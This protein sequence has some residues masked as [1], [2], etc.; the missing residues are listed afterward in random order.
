MQ[1]RVADDTL[2][3][4]VDTAQ[5]IIAETDSLYFIP[6]VRLGDVPFDFGGDDQFSGHNGYAPCV[7]PLPKSGPRPDYS[8]D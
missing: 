6:I 7:G 8:P 4:R 2:D 3:A 1:F 5:K